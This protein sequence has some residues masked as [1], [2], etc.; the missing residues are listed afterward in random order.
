MAIH[1]PTFNIICNTDPQTYIVRHW[2][3]LPQAHKRSVSS[4]IAWV[5]VWITQYCQRA[6]LYLEIPMKYLVTMTERCS[7]LARH[8]PNSWMWVEK[9]KWYIVSVK[10]WS[11]ATAPGSPC[12]ILALLST[13]VRRSG[14]GRLPLPVKDAPPVITCLWPTLTLHGCHGNSLTLL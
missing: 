14:Q 7:N 9:G 8:G 5:L 11:T 12:H 4:G 6:N 13:S 1:C 3:W 2:L 10:I